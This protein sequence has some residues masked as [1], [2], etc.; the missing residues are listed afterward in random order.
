MFMLND[1]KKEPAA[2]TCP[3]C[4]E[5]H[6]A[7]TFRLHLLFDKKQINRI[8]ADH[9]GWQDKEGCCFLCANLYR[10]EFGLPPLS[11]EEFYALGLGKA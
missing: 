5:K 4:K 9:P 8:R 7:I 2:M 6:S 1:L 11:K 3:L 10:Q